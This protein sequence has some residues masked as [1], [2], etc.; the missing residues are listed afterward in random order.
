MLVLRYCWLAAQQHSCVI[1]L[2][3]TYLY[4]KGEE[5]RVVVIMISRFTFIGLPLHLLIFSP[6][7][8]ETVM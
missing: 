5:E 3:G 2:L 1:I 4:N 6:S 7:Y 8:D